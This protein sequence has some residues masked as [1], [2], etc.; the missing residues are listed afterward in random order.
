MR[1]YTLIPK[2]NKGCKWYTSK[3]N[4]FKTG[5]IEAVDEDGSKTLVNIDNYIIVK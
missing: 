5:Y 3:E 2:N 1:E 4:I